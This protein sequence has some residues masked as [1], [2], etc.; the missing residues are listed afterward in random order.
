MKQ[1]SKQFQLLPKTEMK[2]A[3]SFGGILRNTRKGRQG[4]RPLATKTSMHLVLRSSKATGKWALNYGNN[5]QRI[6]EI[7]WKF[8]KKYGVKIHSLANVGNHLHIHMQLSSRHTY[9]KFICAVSSAVVMQITKAKAGFAQKNSK[10]E[11]F[12]D[13]R[14]FTRIL[15]TWSEFLRLKDYVAINKFEGLGVPRSK[16]VYMVLG[17][18]KFKASG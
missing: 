13:Y 7:F 4:P 5:H 11:R 14:P 8:S 1:K 17:R 9:K 18:G 15:Q 6:R 16:A 3:K 10:Y 2:S 12:W